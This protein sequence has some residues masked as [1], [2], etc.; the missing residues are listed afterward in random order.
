MSTRFVSHLEKTRFV[1]TLMLMSAFWEVTRRGLVGIYQRFGGMYCLHVQG[2]SPSAQRTVV[3]RLWTTCHA[4]QTRKPA[5]K[6]RVT[7]RRFGGEKWADA[8]E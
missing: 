1:G 4:I 6:Y 5:A 8:G 3:A 7:K 2:G